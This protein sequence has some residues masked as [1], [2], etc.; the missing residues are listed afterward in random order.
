MLDSIAHAE[1]KVGSE[2]SFGI[3]FSIFFF[4]VAIYPLLHQGDVHIWAI[5]ISIGLL[6]LA[7]VYPNLLRAPNRLWFKF[8]VFL[9]AIVA[10]VVM[11]LVYVV[12]VVPIGFIM[13]L[14][15]IDI[16]NKK[17]DPTK[18]SYWQD[19]KTSPSTMKDQF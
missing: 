11:F 12:T 19:K 10:P 17:I 15:G 9:G 8:G 14:F 4:L 7:Y 13:K 16:I 6:F 5:L 3:V 2:K 18:Q 1:E